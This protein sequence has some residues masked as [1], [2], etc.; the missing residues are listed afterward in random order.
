MLSLVFGL[1]H[2]L[3]GVS[4]KETNVLINKLRKFKKRRGFQ[5]NSEHWKCCWFSSLPKKLKKLS[6]F[7]K[8][9]VSYIEYYRFVHFNILRNKMN[10][11]WV[12]QF[13]LTL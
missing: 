9:T 1:I 6:N 5:C 3:Q 8:K 11:A 10:F 2:Y 12:E 4:T 7:V 13:F